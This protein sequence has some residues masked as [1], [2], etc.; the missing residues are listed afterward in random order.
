MIT[1]LI[2]YIAG[3]LS[4]W[5]GFYLHCKVVGSFTTGEV[6]LT[7]IGSLIPFGNLLGFCWLVALIVYLLSRSDIMQ[8]E[9]YVKPFK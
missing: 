7:G 5:L 4:C 9:W 3:M 8:K 6:T 1:V 2:I